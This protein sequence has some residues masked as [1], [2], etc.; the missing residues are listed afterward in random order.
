[1]FR[2]VT[3]N[4]LLSSTL[5]ITACGGG[6]SSPTGGGSTTTATIEL[7]GKNLFF[8]SNLSE[9][10]GQAC[11]DCHDP[12]AAFTDPSPNLNST[13]PVSEGAVNGRFGNRN[14]PTAMYAS[15]SPIFGTGQ[16]AN[17]NSIYIGGQFLD[18][19]A[20]DLVEQA[21][22]PFLNTLEM[23]NPT[24]ASVVEKVKN[25][26]YADM[27][28]AVFGQNAFSNIDTAYEN[29]AKAI[30]AFEKTTLFHPF[31]SKYDY[32]LRGMATFTQEEQRGF[33]LFKSQKAKCANCHTLATSQNEPDLFTNFGF[34]NV[35]TPPNDNNPFGTYPGYVDN[36][37]ADSGRTDLNLPNVDERGLFKTPTLRN[38]ELTAP[39]MHNGVYDTLEQVVAH[40]NREDLDLIAEVPDTISADV[41]FLG[42]TPSEEADLVAFLKTLT[43]GYVP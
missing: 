11:A 22:G 1:M 25:S 23:N 7:L 37:L 20:N 13:N 21:M 17:G 9:P 27:F 32:V 41:G 4:L 26:N 19:R 31:T 18:G 16:D 35:G 8:D 36:G 43:D 42:L 3:R 38:V 6:G 24:K 14:A 28:T 30:A 40:Y 34:F 2:N 39:Y 29:I 33:D 12:S 5:L 10:T 15:F